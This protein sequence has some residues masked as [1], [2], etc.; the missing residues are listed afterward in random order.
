ML[1]NGTWRQHKT[2][3]SNTAHTGHIR[4]LNTELDSQVTHGDLDHGVC[5]H[6]CCLFGITLSDGIYQIYGGRLNLL[7]KWIDSFWV[8]S[9]SVKCV[10]TFRKK[11]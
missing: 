6:I 4:A 3:T 1:L 11:D 8:F 10:F 7:K 5:V 2:L 9:K